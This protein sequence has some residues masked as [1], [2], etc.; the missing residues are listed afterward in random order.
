MFLKKQRY[1]FFDVPDMFF[2]W[3][4]KDFL[5]NKY[6]VVDKKTNFIYYDAILW[7]KTG[8][9]IYPAVISLTFS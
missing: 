9:I 3:G 5:S 8:K 1:V 6:A 4:R 2:Q 7:I